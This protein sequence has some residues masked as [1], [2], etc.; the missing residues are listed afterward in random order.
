VRSF[1]LLTGLGVTV[2]FHQYP[3]FLLNDVS[4]LGQILHD[5]VGAAFSDANPCG[6]LTQPYPRVA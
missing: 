6:D 4:R 1:Y 5:A 3:V 2:G